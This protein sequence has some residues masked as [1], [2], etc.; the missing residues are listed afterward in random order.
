MY[1][2][3]PVCFVFVEFKLPFGSAEA[4]YYPRFRTLTIQT[5]AHRRQP[6][7]G[8]TYP[9]E[10]LPNLPAC[11]YP[12]IGAVPGASAQPY[13]ST[14]TRHTVYTMDALYQLDQLARAV[15][16]MRDLQA[17]ISLRYFQRIDQSVFAAQDRVDTLVARV[18]GDVCAPIPPHV[19]AQLVAGS[20]T[21]ECPPLLL[22][23]AYAVH[24]PPFTDEVPD[25]PPPAPPTPPV[26]QQ[27]D[28]DAPEFPW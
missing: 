3:P 5:A 4:S 12:V 21:A 2:P 8:Q 14:D 10:H 7:F 15:Q 18:L 1:A 24:F 22:P 23:S 20:F 19:V 11:G 17:P 27:R 26:P 13:Y 16:H 28:L 9:H 6:N 25:L